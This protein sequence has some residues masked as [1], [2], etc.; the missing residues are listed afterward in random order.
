MPDTLTTTALWD[1]PRV[2]APSADATG[3]VVVVP[4]TTTGD[5]AVTQLW[6]LVPGADP[7]PLTGGASASSPVVAPDGRHVAFVRRVDDRP[8][9]FVLPLDGGEA[10]QVT[11]LPLGIVGSARWVGG[12]QLLV[13]TRLLDSDPTPAATAAWRDAADQR[14]GLRATERRL[15]RAWDTWFTDPLTEHVL[16][17]DLTDPDAEPEDLTP[18]TWLLPDPLSDP[19]RHLDVS[20]NGRWL[21]VTTADPDGDVDGVPVPRLHVVDLTDP[22]RPRCL[23]A[24]TRG[25][26]GAPRFLPDG[27]VLVAIRRERD[28]YAAPEDLWAV[29]PTDGR[30]DPVLVD[31]DDQ[32]GSVAVGPDGRVVLGSEVRGRGRLLEVVDGG[33]VPLAAPTSGGLSAPV[34]TTTGVYALHSSVTAPPEVARVTDDVEVVTAFTRPSLADT[35]LGTLEERTVTGADGDDVQV[36]VL[37]PPAPV[38]TG[39]GPP[40]LVHLLHGG[41][42]ST[43][44]DTWHWRW[45]AA[46]FAAEGWVVAMVNFHGSTSFGHDFTGSIHGDWGSR[47]TQDV[48]AATD[49]LVGDGTVDPGRMAIAGGSYGGYLTVWLTTQTD[50][51][52]T[53]VAHAAVTDFAGMWA[54]DWNNGFAG[55]FGGELWDDPARTLRFSPSWHYGGM[56]TPMLVLHGDNDLRVPIDQGRALYGVLQAMRIPSRLVVFPSEN[57]W[58]LDRRNSEAW[59]G[60][61][62]DWLHRTL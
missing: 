21:A 62:L 25:A 18:G 46:R 2:G 11:D 49:D 7:L 22:G 43:F 35:D 19:A 29:D 50:R 6:R 20:P 28:W 4:V 59:Y 32:L 47:P 37:H 15:S 55:A 54:T 39:E 9:L 56:S 17:V 26:T 51:F 33:V 23:T 41:P 5:T 10:R 48:L 8:Q 52:A 36:F 45:C 14:P 61:V 34:V 3:E 38:V 31:H 58:V 53:A 42:H 24:D 27:R 60:E 1:L 12:D 16:R 44:G 13:A 30:R 40:P 57:H